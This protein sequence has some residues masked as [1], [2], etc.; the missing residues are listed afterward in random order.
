MTDKHSFLERLTS[1]LA[2]RGISEA[3]A[4]AYLAQFDRYYERMANDDLATAETLLDIESIA[5]N[6]ASQVAQ[7]REQADLLTEQTLNLPMVDIDNEPTTEAQIPAVSDDDLDYEPL[8]LIA[9]EPMQDGED[10]VEYEEYEALEEV[11]LDVAQENATRLP[12][13]VEEEKIQGTKMFWGLFALSLP[14]TIP[15]ALLILGIFGV[16]WGAVAAVMAGAVAALIGV[17]CLGTVLSLVGIIYGI[18]QMGNA[19]PIGL[20]EIG[21]GV[22]IAGI[23]LC[24]GILIYNFAIR[25][26]PVLF[27]LVWKLFKYVLKR[28]KELFNHLK[29]E[30]AKL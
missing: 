11:A 12:D 16:M 28:L 19:V 30:S 29:K 8:S 20:Y 17:V 18:L 21:I 6:I 15:L 22:V 26:V 24:I 23:T 9:D 2:A 27:K 14:V 13:Y 25:L 1:M 10:V 3:E 5:D 4:E 7:K